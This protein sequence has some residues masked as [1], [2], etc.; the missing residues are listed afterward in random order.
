MIV[1][2]VLDNTALN[3]LVALQ[4]S[5]NPDIAAQIIG[6]F[7]DEMPASV[8]A[9]TEGVAAADF[10]AVRFAA[11]SIKSSAAYVGACALSTTCAQIERSAQDGNLPECVVLSDSLESLFADTL[12]A[13]DEFDLKVA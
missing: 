13:L 4:C 2:Q 1:T 10:E 12:G 3:A 9:I 5:G 8:S 6:L 7:R 11:H